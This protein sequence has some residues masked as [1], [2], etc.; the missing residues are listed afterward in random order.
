MTN[1]FD[2]AFGARRVLLLCALLLLAR[3]AT[4]PLYPLADRTESRYA[5]I[6]RTMHATGDWVTPRLHGEPFW[7]KPPLSTWAQASGIGLLGRNELAVRLPAWLAGLLTL[8][9]VWKSGAVLGGRSI[10]RAGALLFLCSPIT[11]FLVGGVMT[12]PYLV[13]GTALALYGMLARAASDSRMSSW[14]AALTVGI[15]VGIATL[16]KGPIGV[17][18]GAFPF[19]GLL[20]GR[21]GRAV[22]KAWPWVRMVV[23]FGAVAAPWYVIAEQRTPGFLDYFIVGEHFR[24]YLDSDWA[25]DRYG[26]AHAEPLGMIWLHFALAIVAWLPLVGLVLHRERG[27]LQLGALTRHPELAAATAATFLPLLFFTFSRNLLPT[28]VYPTLAPAALLLAHGLQRTPAPGGVWLPRIVRWMPNAVAAITVLIVVALPFVPT[29]AWVRLSHRDIVARTKAPVVVY[30]RDL[31]YIY[32]PI[33]YT[34]GRAVGVAG[35]EDPAWAA[36]RARPEDA[37]VLTRQRHMA[38]IPRDLLERLELQED[39]Y[40]HYQIWRVR[41]TGD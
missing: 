17:V 9:L 41:P 24:R 5:E 8:L 38:Q 3:L 11:L 27:R 40:G 30:A 7:G 2:R 15:G 39:V 6:A 28:Y 4:L 23:V 10:A 36:V 33:F 26:F 29:S 37:A 16:A 32:S 20:F 13:L 22:L 34:D 25:G 12:D 35:R 31:T 14:R 18:L 21:D 1:E 19:V